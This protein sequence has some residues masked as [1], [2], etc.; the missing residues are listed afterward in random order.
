MI[1]LPNQSEV[2]L[3]KLLPD[4]LGLQRVEFDNAFSIGAE[5]NHGV[6]SNEGILGEV[7][8]FD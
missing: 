4:L 8:R 6:L 3:A 1:D 2:K 5:E 7:N